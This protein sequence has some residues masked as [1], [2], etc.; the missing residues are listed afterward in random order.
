[1]GV[2]CHNDLGLATANTLAAIEAGV[3]YPSVTVNGIGERAGNPPLH[4]VA[5]ALEKVLRRRHGIDM[6]RLYDLSQLVERCS[7]IF[8]SPH[9]PIMGLNAFRHESGVHVDGILK[10]SKVYKGLDPHK[11]GK[12]SSF[13]LGKHTGTRA[14][15]HLLQ[16]RGYEANEEE[17]KEILRRV[18]E[19]K[20]AEGKEEIRRMVGEVAL[21]YERYLNFPHEA[22][23]EI[24]E[25]VLRKDG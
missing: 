15:Q 19:R 12:D 23:W 1:M 24:V 22:F 20:V 9:A 13:V 25:G 21:F 5:V 6:Q 18:K 16:E 10:N 3:E 2:H 4:E 8:I 14:I 11:V 7:G 17:L